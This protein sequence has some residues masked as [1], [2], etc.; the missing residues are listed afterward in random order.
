[1]RQFWVHHGGIALALVFMLGCVSHQPGGLWEIDMGVRQLVETGTVL[2]DHRYYYLGS[3]TAPDTII[4]ISD[5]YTLR[6]RVWA[7]IELSESRLNG[8]LQWWR[9]EHYG[10]GCE[11][12][13]GL[14]LTPDGRQAGIWYSRNIVNI[15]RMP[16]PGVLEIYQP[17]TITGS[18]CEQEHDN[19]LWG[20]WF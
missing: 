11:F 17:R 15:V 3:I 8:W 2:P 4:A 13:G 20:G 18:T 1:M 19:G 7:E 9:T 16:E 5:Q 12:R 6:S 10:P 14:I